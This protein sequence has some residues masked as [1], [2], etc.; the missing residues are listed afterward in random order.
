MYAEFIWVCS[1]FP[2]NC[3]N[4]IIP[5]RCFSGQIAIYCNKYVMI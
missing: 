4:I 2:I 1:V 3:D 5:E